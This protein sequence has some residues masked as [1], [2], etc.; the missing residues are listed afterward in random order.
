MMLMLLAAAA[1]ASSASAQRASPVPPAGEARNVVERQF[2]SP[3][4]SGA[5][6]GLTADEAE[7]V[8]KRYLASI[9]QPVADDRQVQ[10]K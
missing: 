5:A 6:A 3:P 9:G 2:L 7:V 8:M 4:R 10:P 1:A